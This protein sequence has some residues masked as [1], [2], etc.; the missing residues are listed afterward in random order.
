MKKKNNSSSELESAV[1]S[2]KLY[3]E[4]LLDEIRNQIVLE[5]QTYLA[6]D[7]VSLEDKERA[8]QQQKAMIKEVNLLQERCISNLGTLQSDHTGVG[9]LDS[10]LSN[11][12]WDE[13]EAILKMEKD[14]DYTLYLRQK[15]LFMNQGL[16]FLNKSFLK[17]LSSREYPEML[18]GAL[19]IVKDE[20]LSNNSVKILKEYG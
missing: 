11:L 4:Y 15:L 7:D 9:E 2:P 19:L 1:N 12:Y 16:I 3:I 10:H 8:K 6:K 18:F 5:Y 20:Y 14:Q 17:G 13:T